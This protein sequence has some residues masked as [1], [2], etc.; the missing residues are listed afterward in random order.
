M[1][2]FIVAKA[3]EIPPGTGKAVFAGDKAV[4][5]FNVGGTFYAID[6]I[7]PHRGG[8]LGEGDLEDR[9]VICPWHGWQFELE[10][11]NS[12]FGANVSTYKVTVDP[13][14]NEV[15]IDV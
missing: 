5:V 2:E 9:T 6:N 1:A 10:T 12:P 8:P 14:T 3:D 7:C 4:A 11:G 13:A 15:K